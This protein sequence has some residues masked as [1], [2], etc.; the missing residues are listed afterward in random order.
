MFILLAFFGFGL[1][2]GSFLNALLWRMREGMTLG[3]RSMCP[4]CRAPIAW[5]DNVPVLSFI[6]LGGKC[7]RCRADISWRYPTVEIMTGVLFALLGSAFFSWWNVES[8][9]VTVF[10]LVAGAILVLI[11]LFDLETMEIPNILLWI[12]VGWGLPMLLLLDAYGFHPGVS[13]WS[14]RL[15]SGILAGL[16]AF[17]PLFLMAALSREKWMGMGD[18]FLAFFLGLVV[19]WPHILFALIL[20]FGIGALVGVS[21]ILLKKKEMQSHIPLGPFLILGAFLALFLPEWFPGIF[22]SLFWWG[23]L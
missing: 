1:I 16:V 10:Y 8:W 7:R 2:I 4:S 5:Y 20:A 14:L 6:F 3:G 18:G 15:Y 13:V 9:I 12:G 23:L 22:E 21:L 19:G 11:F 17:L